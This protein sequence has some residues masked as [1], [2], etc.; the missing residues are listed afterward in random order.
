MDDDAKGLGDED[1]PLALT[2][3]KIIAADDDHIWTLEDL[4]DRVDAER[5]RI[6]SALD[7]LVERSI[8]Q[9]SEERYEITDRERLH[10]AYQFQRTTSRFNELLG[11]EDPDDWNTSRKK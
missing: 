10:S 9:Q 2:L 6:E 11:R 8:L 5:S 3:T 4:T 7:H 1:E